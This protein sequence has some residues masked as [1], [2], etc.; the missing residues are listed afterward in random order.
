[1]ILDD[2][3]YMN[4]ID[5]KFKFI[6]NHVMKKLDES[7]CSFID[8]KYQLYINDQLVIIEQFTNYVNIIIGDDIFTYKG[9]KICN[10]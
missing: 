2:V 9:E 6:Y 1:M 4:N 8:N 3:L 5:E 10:Y 7:D